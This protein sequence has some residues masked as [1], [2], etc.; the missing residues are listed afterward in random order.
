MPPSDVLCLTLSF[1]VSSTDVTTDL[2]QRQNEEEARVEY[3][4]DV[5]RAEARVD[6]SP[7]AQSMED[8]LEN[9]LSTCIVHKTDQN[10]H[11]KD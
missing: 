5:P 2:N 4:H 8:R 9:F 7:A 10:F 1:L 11:T 6:N 3:F